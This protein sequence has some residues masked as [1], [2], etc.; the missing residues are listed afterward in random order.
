V[1]IQSKKDKDAEEE[2]YRRQVEEE[3]LED[4]RRKLEAERLKK[5]ES[6]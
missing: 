1:E 2:F 5:L 6:R 3:K 4:D